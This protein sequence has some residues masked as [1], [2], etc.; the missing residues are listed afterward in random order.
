MPQT[1]TLKRCTASL[2]AEDYAALHA[3]VE[4]FN[5]RRRLRPIGDVPPAE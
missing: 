2:D 1:K 4:W 5:N 3:L